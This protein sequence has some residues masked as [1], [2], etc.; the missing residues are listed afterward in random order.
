MLQCNN[1]PLSGI[2]GCAS[3]KVI[4]VIFTQ[5]AHIQQQQNQAKRQIKVPL[6][7]LQHKRQIFDVYFVMIFCASLDC[8]GPREILQ[9]EGWIGKIFLS[10]LEKQNRLSSSSK[11][12]REIASIRTLKEV[13]ICQIIKLQGKSRAIQV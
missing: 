3:S 4:M 6:I 5:V 1:N 11:A 9:L 7:T 12:C 13:I 8:K 10:D 2:K